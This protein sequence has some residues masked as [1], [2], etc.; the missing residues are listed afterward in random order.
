[1][2]SERFL[3]LDR[4]KQERIL[5]AAREEF[6]RVP[7]EEVSI[8]Q[9][10]K[11]AEISRGSFYT[12]FVDKEDLLSYIYERQEEAMECSLR[13]KLLELRGD[14]WQVI[15]SWTREVTGYMDSP[16]VREFLQILIHTNMGQKMFCLIDGQREKQR[17]ERE[18]ECVEWFLSHVDAGVLD[19]S[20][21]KEELEVLYR[22]LRMAAVMAL[23][24]VMTHPEE[25]EKSLRDLDREIEILRRGINA[26]LPRG[27]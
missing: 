24:Y 3:K 18:R 13:A 1:M 7:Y 26:E 11:N 16:Q 20:R 4:E 2:A 10:I 25:K 22:M 14:I 19:L 23:G 8:N 27:T 12:Y 5:R 21:P 15:R 6:A 17:Q 9:I